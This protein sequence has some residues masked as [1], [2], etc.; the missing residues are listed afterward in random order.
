M[1]N[2]VT[3]IQNSVVEFM[4]SFFLANGKMPTVREIGVQLFNVKTTNGVKGHLDRLAAKGVIVLGDGKSRSIKIVGWNPIGNGNSDSRIGENYCVNL[5]SGNRVAFMI[6]SDEGMVE[7]DVYNL[8]D[9]VK[10]ADGRKVDASLAVIDRLAKVAEWMVS[11]R[12]KASA[13]VAAAE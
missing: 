5:V 1:S 2:E 12:I 4:K 7:A 8:E 11:K 6:F 10:V 9:A 13:K 3:A